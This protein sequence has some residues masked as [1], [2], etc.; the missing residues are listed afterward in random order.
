[1]ST[2]AQRLELPAGAVTYSTGDLKQ[3]A[4]R[5]S[6]YGARFLTPEEKQK[7]IRAKM[8]TPVGMIG[9]CFII[10]GDNGTWQYQGYIRGEPAPGI[11]LVQFFSALDGTQ[12]TM[13]LIRIEDM[14]GAHNWQK[15]G[16][17]L[18]F[19]DDEYLRFWIEYRASSV[20]LLDAG[21]EM[22]EA[23]LRRGGKF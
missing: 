14:M 5:L 20:R 3:T 18:F 1:M 21:L 11:F 23:H 15:P 9:R 13:G 16:T 7:A 8:E 22:V 10:W 6:E 17:F 12:T 2:P 4:Q 19:E